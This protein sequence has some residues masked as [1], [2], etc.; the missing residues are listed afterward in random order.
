MP[1]LKKRVLSKLKESRLKVL[2]QL[3]NEWNKLNQIDLKASET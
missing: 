2:E 1:D 3:V